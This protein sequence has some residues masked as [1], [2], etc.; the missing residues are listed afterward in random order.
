MST[1]N[2]YTIVDNNELIIYTSSKLL[3]ISIY[4]YHRVAKYSF[5]SVEHRVRWLSY[6]ILECPHT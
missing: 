6:D 1:N 2:I 4:I 5:A 3:Y